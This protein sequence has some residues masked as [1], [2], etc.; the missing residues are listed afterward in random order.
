VAWEGSEMKLFIYRID[1]QP[2]ISLPRVEFMKFFDEI[3]YQFSKLEGSITYCAGKTVRVSK[4][5]RLA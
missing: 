5:A 4:V 2:D 1:L 3:A